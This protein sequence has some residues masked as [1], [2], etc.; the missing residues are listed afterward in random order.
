[1]THNHFPYL[2]HFPRILLVFF[3]I[4]NI[5]YTTARHKTNAN[6]GNLA[7]DEVEKR[8]YFMIRV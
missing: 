6:F 8:M 5:I 7:S 3:F 1:M 2:I 4:K